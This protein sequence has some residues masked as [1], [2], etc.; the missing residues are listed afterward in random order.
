[1]QQIAA[2]GE[3]DRSLPPGRSLSSGPKITLSRSGLDF[4]DNEIAE[5]NKHFLASN[6]KKD[7]QPCKTSHTYDKQS[8]PLIRDFSPSLT[9]LRLG[10]PTSNLPAEPTDD[11]Q[12]RGCPYGPQSSPTKSMHGSFVSSLLVGAAAK[13]IGDLVLPKPKGTLIRQFSEAT[14]H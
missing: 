11:G 10:T 9:R 5:K 4:I 14:S 6:P 7:N 1:M 13:Q 12:Q 8:L 3:R 2:H